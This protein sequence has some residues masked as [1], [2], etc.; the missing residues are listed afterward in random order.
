MH[1]LALTIR[2]D[3]P[4]CPAVLAYRI[5]QPG[6]KLL[7][8]VWQTPGEQL[9]RTKTAFCSLGQVTIGAQA[10]DSGLNRCPRIPDDCQVPAP[11]AVVAR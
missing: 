7:L 6:D 9:P 10:A 2:R 4:A 11:A 1:Y 3:A 5:E 8:A